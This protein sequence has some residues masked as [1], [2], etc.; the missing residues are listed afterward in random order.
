[1]PDGRPHVLYD[2]SRAW[3]WCLKVGPT[4]CTVWPVKD[5]VL[6]PES[7]PYVLYDLSRTWCW[8]LI[9]GPGYLI[10]DTLSILYV[11]S[12]HRIKDPPSCRLYI[13]FLSFVKPLFTSC[14]PLIQERLYSMAQWNMPPLKG[15]MSV[16]K[17]LLTRWD[18]SPLPRFLVLP[19]STLLN[20]MCLNPFFNNTVCTLWVMVVG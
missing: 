5:L 6:M 7:R 17:I 2:L 11:E 14:Y 10:S 18:L 15:A 3:C 4:Y 1:M 8:C 19:Q 16:F 13:Y 9:V 20:R 12:R